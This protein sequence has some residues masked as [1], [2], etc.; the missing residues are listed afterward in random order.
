[1]SS[2]AVLQTVPFDYTNYVPSRAPGRRSW[3]SVVML[4]AEAWRFRYLFLAQKCF[5]VLSSVNI[6]FDIYINLFL[7]HKGHIALS[8]VH[9]TMLGV[10][11]V[12]HRTL[13]K[14]VADVCRVVY[15]AK[16]SLIKVSIKNVP[17]F[18][19]SISHFSLLLIL[20]V[21]F[22]ILF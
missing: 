19:S 5:S 3:T 13:P 20:I 9:P 22:V 7:L 21:S 4:L 17:C 18:F 6:L 11:Q 10:D 2:G 12:K 8:L 14:S 15:Q 16:C 1:M